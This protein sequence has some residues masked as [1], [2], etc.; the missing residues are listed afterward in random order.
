MTGWTY[1]SFPPSP[2]LAPFVHNLWGV[3]GAAFYHVESTLPD[4]AV[5]LMVSLGPSHRVVAYGDRRANDD[6]SGAWV[7]GIQDQP[8]VHASPAGSDHVA[9]RF[10]P[11]GAHAFFG[12]PMNALKNSVIPLDDLWDRSAV[13]R[14]IERLHEAD[15]DEGRCRT[16]ETCLLEQGVAVHP[17]FGT[18]ARAAELLRGDSRGS[19]V[20]EVCTRLGLSNRYLIEQFRQTVGLTPKSYARVER[21]QRVIRACRGRTEVSW[22]RLAAELGFADQPHLIRDFR[23]LT[24]VTPEEFLASR[25]PDQSHL[26][27]E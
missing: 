16:L 23:R 2:Q 4:G 6:F 19:P 8:L 13:S 25:T 17:S 26:V 15:G 12:I 22:S 24:L 9:V 21:L 18:A 3:R 7:A 14:L 20:G 10:R 27:V 5:Q 11:G 1:F